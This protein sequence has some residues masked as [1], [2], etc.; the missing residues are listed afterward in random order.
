MDAATGAADA[1]AFIGLNTGAF[2]FNHFHVDADGVAGAEFGHAALAKTLGD[3]LFL[4]LGDNIH[5]NAFQWA[6]ARL[7]R[8]IGERHSF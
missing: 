4:E 7:S 6:P 2:A 1:H 8:P 5:N 3:L